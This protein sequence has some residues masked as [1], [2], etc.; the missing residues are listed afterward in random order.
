M[1]YGKN[2][3]RWLA[4]KLDFIQTNPKLILNEVY[5]ALKF[6]WKIRS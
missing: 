6:I 2:S 4:L 3:Y 1:Y 5:V